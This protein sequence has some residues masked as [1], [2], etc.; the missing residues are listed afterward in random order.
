MCITQTGTERVRLARNEK[1]GLTVWTLAKIGFLF[2]I[3]DGSLFF[4]SLF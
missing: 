4:C 2:L 1:S 3:V